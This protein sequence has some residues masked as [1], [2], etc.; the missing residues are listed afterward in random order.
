MIKLVNA[1]RLPDEKIPAYAVGP[2]SRIYGVYDS[3]VDESHRS[4]DKQVTLGWLLL[5]AGFIVS[6]LSMLVIYQP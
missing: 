2:L 4:L 1:N 6:M 5:G 3:Y